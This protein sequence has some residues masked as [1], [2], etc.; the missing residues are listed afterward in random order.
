VNDEE[1]I[2]RTRAVWA[3]GDYAVVGDLFAQVGDDT[4]AA[5]AVAGCDV[6]DV[7]T[8]TGNTLRA[9]A[10]A[11]ARSVRGID[12]TPEL[13]DIARVRAAAAGIEAVF[14]VG[15]AEALP[16]GSAMFDRV[17]STFGVMFAPDQRRAAGEL[18]RVCRPGGR[19]AVTAWMPDGLFGR[20]SSTLAAFLPA[21]PPPGPTP[22]DWADPA[23]VQA[24]VAGHDRPAVASTT[25]ETVTIRAASTDALVECFATLSGP[26]L[27]MRAVLEQTGR[28]GDA[29]A[30][31][32]ETYDAANEAT[33]GT[34][35]APVTYARTI[36]S[37]G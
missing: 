6:L 21:P 25:V 8:G 24:L 4:V 10:A 16:Y 36:V 5:L 20:M 19:V 3:S 1:R 11:G 35:Q 37:I 31:L 14:D 32:H 9:A 15:D 12:V 30:A 17:V 26:V 18:V 13:L 28:W 23:H 27:P 2:A 33:D 22:S 29:R 34:Y 7:A